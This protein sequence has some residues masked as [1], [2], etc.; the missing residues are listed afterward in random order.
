MKH[1]TFIIYTHFYFFKFCCIWWNQNSVAADCSTR[2]FLVISTFPAKS[3]G[4]GNRRRIYLLSVR[5]ASCG[6]HFVTSTTFG[7]TEW[8]LLPNTRICLLL[9]LGKGTSSNQMTCP[10]PTKWQYSS[11]STMHLLK[12]SLLAQVTPF[13]SLPLQRQI[14]LPQKYA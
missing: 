14:S 7:P 4:G 11:Q 10:R 3:T 12:L 1:Q 13:K 5:L 9:P 8:I 6:V 2:E